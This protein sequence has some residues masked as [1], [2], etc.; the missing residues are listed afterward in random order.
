MSAWTW[1]ERITSDDDTVDAYLASG[2]IVAKE[3]DEWDFYTALEWLAT[4]GAENAEDQTA[5]AMANVIK[6]LSVKADQK[7]ARKAITAAKRAYAAENGIPVS[8]V[9]IVK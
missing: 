8:Q 4:Y 5:Q 1:G 2:E 7:I 6:F 9:R 3:P